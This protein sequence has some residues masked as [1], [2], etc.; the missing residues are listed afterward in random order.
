LVDEALF[1]GAAVFDET[2]TVRVAWPIDPAERRFDVGPE[3]AQRLHVA[4]MLG[5]EPGQQHE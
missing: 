2:V 3:L 1:V 4:C 5:I